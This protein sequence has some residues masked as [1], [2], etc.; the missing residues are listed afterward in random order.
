MEEEYLVSPSVL[1]N[2]E[3]SADCVVRA[4]E[5]LMNSGAEVYRVEETMT[6]LGESIPGVTQCISYVMVTG[7]LCSVQADNITVTRIARMHT[8][9]RNLALVSAINDLARKAE[10]EHYSP[11]EL[12]KRIEEAQSVPDYS[13]LTKSLWGAIGAAGFSVFF[14][15]GP[16]ELAFVFLI[17]LPIRFCSIMLEKLRINEYLV[18]LALAFV[19]AAGAVIFH[20]LV[21]A[22]SQSNMIISSIMLLVPG[23]MITNALRDSV[24]DEPLSALVL[25]MQA[26]LIACSIAI[27]V[28]LGLYVME[29]F[30]A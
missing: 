24:M 13:P 25:L 6:R 11:D 8:S 27:G 19:A 26:L 16:I 2:V 18:N 4:G 29:G 28:L 3:K 20:R 12:M 9:S 17:G 14:G 10:K 21:P 5:L 1:A 15:G 23:L 30:I 7:I 22:S